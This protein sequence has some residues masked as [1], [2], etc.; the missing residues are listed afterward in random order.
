MEQYSNQTIHVRFHGRSEELT[1]ASLAVSH[2]SQDTA[3]KEAIAHH[4]DLPPHTLDQHVVIRT[5]QAIIVR[6]EAIY[7]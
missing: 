6:P 7:G 3:L 5:S 2:T 4:F 1:E